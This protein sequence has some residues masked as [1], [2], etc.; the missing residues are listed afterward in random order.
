MQ[1]KHHNKD[2]CKTRELR[3]GTRRETDSRSACLIVGEPSDG[4]G[5][6]VAEH[7]HRLLAHGEL[8]A[9]AR[10]RLELVLHRVAARV[11]RRA[12]CATRTAA[13]P[14]KGAAP[15]EGAA[16]GHGEGIAAARRRRLRRRA[17]AD[18]AERELVPNGWLAPR[19][20]RLEGR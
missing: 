8:E 7:A 16:R 18:R 6:V 13:D 11:A 4:C 1:V 10:E 9:H 15:V 3:F 17:A 2:A 20:L 12:A 5:G 19:V 14:A